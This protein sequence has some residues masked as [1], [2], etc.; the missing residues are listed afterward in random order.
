MVT[1]LFTTAQ[2]DLLASRGEELSAEDLIQLEKQMIEEEE[3]IP[4]PEPKRFTRQ[5][6]AGGFTLIEEGLSRFEAEDPNME[7][8]G[9]CSDGV[10]QTNEVAEYG[11]MI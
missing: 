7:S 4:T 6:L 3:D 1:T 9:E 5:G 10:R 8:D 11:Y 2:F